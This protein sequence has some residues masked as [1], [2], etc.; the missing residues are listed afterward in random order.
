MNRDRAKDEAKARIE[1]Y[2]RGKGLPLTR[3]FHCLNPLHADAHA[4]MSYDRDRQRVKCFAC[5]AVYDLFDLVGLDYGL[6]DFPAK[7]AKA[8]ELYNIPLDEL[9]GSR[10]DPA[11]RAQ[12]KPAQEAKPAADPA[13]PPAPPADYTEYILA[14]AA[15]LASP[16][17]K[18]G[19]D[20]LRKRGISEATAQAEVLGYDPAYYFNGYG[21]RPAIIIMTS[22]YSFVAR[23]IDPNAP[24]GAR[25]RKK[26][27]IA[28]FGGGTLPNAKTPVFVTEGELDAISIRE[29]GGEAV[30]LG[31]TANIGLLVE[32]VKDKRPA[33]PFILALDNDKRG[34]EAQD[35][36]KAGLEQLQTVFTLPAELYGKHKDANEALTADREA[37][38]A[39]IRAAERDASDA[40]EAAAA[41]QTAQEV[42]AQREAQE[43][44][45]AAKAEYL[46][47]SAAAHIAEFENSIKESANTPAIKTGFYSLDGILDGGLYEGLY[48]I[49]A[50]S[51]LGKTTLALQI[52]DNMAAAGQDCLIFSLEMGRSELMAKS[53]SRQTYL[54]AGDNK[55]NA[56]TTRGITA[57]AR[58]ANYSKAELD[59]IQAATAAYKKYAE[60]IFIS[61]GV[62]DI[63]VQQIRET[64]ER[65]KA[66]TGR[67]PVVLI[68]YLQILAP[69]DV[70]ASD[71]QNTDK[72]VLE[73]KRLSRDYKIPVIGI[74]SF[75]RDSYKEGASGRVSLTDFKESGAIEYSADVLI[76]LEFAAATKEDGKAN[77]EYEER[78]EKQKDPREIRLVILKNR[79]G[80]AWV[81]TR[82][83]FFPLF[84]Y[85]TDGQDKDGFSAASEG[86]QIP[87]DFT[88][89]KRI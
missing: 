31:S 57:G 28:L 52:M 18:Q 56:K 55:R 9:A 77:K 41:A 17:G 49:G 50:M 69:A 26:G 8:C 66:A 15:R 38:T 84:N 3:P 32:A 63:G 88:K 33:Q 83:K 68:D 25:Y 53:I 51:S 16:E 22:P 36:L 87:F 85:F 86:E 1:E 13:E 60:H 43:K 5:G 74:S 45:E 23:N 30:A 73:L 40:W 44:Q 10:K 35:K 39:R 67:K 58:Y 81:E 7:L 42:R 29:A 24:E 54:L 64:V 89:A 75:N 79:N 82:F 70:R 11:P 19:A 61:E 20:Y 80:Q 34:Q 47:N 46:Q 48:I 21:E 4:S 6:Q 59:L 27:K 72:A 2:L 37:F 14:C 78:K 62:G 12:Q 76:G 65:H 71:K